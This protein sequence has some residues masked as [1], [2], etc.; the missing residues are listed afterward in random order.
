MEA[1]LKLRLEVEGPD[2]RGERRPGACGN[3]VFK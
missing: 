1:T 3:T 2:V